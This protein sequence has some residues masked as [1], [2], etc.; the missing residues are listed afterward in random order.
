[1][2]FLQSIQS[3]H[4]TTLCA[5]CF[6]VPIYPCFSNNLVFCRLCRIFVKTKSICVN[7]L[8][9]N[10]LML[11]GEKLAKTLDKARNFRTDSAF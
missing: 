10:S 9:E 5:V 4:D 6:N 7:N 8:L 3:Y 1:M 11:M 2:K